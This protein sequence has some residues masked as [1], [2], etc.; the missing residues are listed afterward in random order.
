MAAGVIQALRS[1]DHRTWM[2]QNR[3]PE[4]LCHRRYGED[5]LTLLLRSLD[6]LG[7]DRWQ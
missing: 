7:H 4:A 6:S 5:Y 1:I 3:L 2:G